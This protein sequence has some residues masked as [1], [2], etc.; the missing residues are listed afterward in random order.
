MKYLNKVYKTNY[1]KNNKGKWQVQQHSHNKINL[2][3][4]Q[5][6]ILIKI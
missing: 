6:I 1:S 4:N 3:Y 2:I 5:E